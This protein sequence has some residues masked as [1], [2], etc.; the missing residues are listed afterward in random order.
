MSK[1]FIRVDN[2]DKPVALFRLDEPFSPKLWTSG[3]WQYSER[4]I[5]Y[6]EDGFVDLE[7]VSEEEAKDFKPEAFESN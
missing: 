1:Y 5:D 4:L 6:L 2:E 3:S 7:E